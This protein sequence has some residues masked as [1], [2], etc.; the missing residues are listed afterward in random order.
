MELDKRPHRTTSSSSSTTTTT[1]TAAATAELFICFTSRLTNSSSIRLTNKS[2]LSPART[3]HK[4]PPPAAAAAASL[5]TSL[6]RRLRA[7]GSLKGGAGGQSSPMFPSGVVSKKRGCAFENPEPSSPKVTCIGQVRVKT[8]KQT[9]KMKMTR[10]RST[11]RSRRHGGGEMSFRKVE[12]GHEGLSHQNSQSRNQRWVHLPL[13]IC[14]ALRAFGAEI[15]CFL[16]C[17]S[18]C[19]TDGG[20]GREKVVGKEMRSS[21]RQIHVGEKN[22][23]HSGSCGGSVYRWFVS[24]HEGEGEGEGERDN[25]RDIE[26]VVGGDDDDDEEG[27]ERS[28]GTMEKHRGGGFSR[29]GSIFDGIE[30]KDENGDGDGDGDD[31]PRVSICIPPKNALLL[32]R[33]RSD[34]V[35]MEALSKKFWEPTLLPKD[36]E[37]EDEDK[38]EEEDDVGLEEAVKE[39]AEKGEASEHEPAERR[40][41][42]GIDEMCEDLASVRARDEDGAANPTKQEHDQVHKGE[43]KLE[44]AECRDSQLGGGGDQEDEDVKIRRLIE[45]GIISLGCSNHHHTLQNPAEVGDEGE[46]SVSDSIDEE[47]EYQ[48]A[49]NHQCSSPS[50]SDSDS[51]SERNELQEYPQEQEDPIEVLESI[52][53]TGDGVKPPLEG[54]RGQETMTQMRSQGGQTT[55]ED[56]E[57]E[58]KP[59]C[60]RQEKRENDSKEGELGKELKP[61]EKESSSSVLPDCLL[62]MMCEPKLSMEVSKETWVCST[63]FLRRHPERHHRRKVKPTAAPDEPKKK[64]KAG[65]TEANPIIPQPP[66]APAHPEYQPPRSSCSFPVVSSNGGGG[67]LSMVTNMIEQ[68][69]VNAVAYEPFV[70]TRCKSEPLKSS[71]KFAPPTEL[72]CFWRNRKLEPHRPASAFGVGAAGVGC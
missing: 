57:S 20:T 39:Y 72:P 65:S 64:K 8:K 67:R 26:L 31:E 53:G 47:E 52:E 19:I 50:D 36:E 40:M 14:E 43:E 41:Y 56:R 49:E 7:N 61:Q 46:A 33:C 55:H 48:A 69:L 22:N 25:T 21:G 70:L 34:P 11:T 17:K 12:H 32:M 18:P 44:W 9:K 68:K 5:S 15:N 37:E 60:T 54:L 27:E 4:P 42:H 24:L 3:D 63:D 10:T 66:P 45:A 23:T 58:K 38:D 16:P 30:F 13:T 62:L 71:A 2:I 6:S 1:T 29:R 28:R 35:K 51:D 59:G